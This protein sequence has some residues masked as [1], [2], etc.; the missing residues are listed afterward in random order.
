ERT[1]DGSLANEAKLCS[2]ST[3]RL[4]SSE[5]VCRQSCALIEAVGQFDIDLKRRDA[6]APVHLHHDLVRIEHHMARDHG[7]DLLAQ[8]VDEVGLAEHPSFMRE[9]Y[10]QTLPGNRRGAG[11]AAK[12]PHQV[13]T[14]AA[15][16]PSSRFI[17]PLR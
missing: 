3:A 1:L 10:L 17:S 8:D 14:H 2:P 15:L 5:L 9:Q 6:V 4:S 12:Q 13:Q 16:R 7:K 11:A